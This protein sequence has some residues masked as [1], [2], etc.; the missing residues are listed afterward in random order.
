MG[1]Q[2]RR[3]PADWQ[4]PKNEKGH[5]IPLFE[6]SYS[7]D[8]A[9]WDERAAQ[10]AKGLRDDYNGGWQPKEAVYADMCYVEWAGAAPDESDYMPDWPTDQ[11][12]HLQM[13]DNTSEGTPI[14]PVM[15]TPE[16]LAQWLADNEASAFAGMTATYEQWLGTIKRGFAPSAVLV[17][18][19]L[20]SGVAALADTSS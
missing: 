13:Y 4:H 3:V 6:R 11:C 19:H 5:Y 10:W 1:R 20:E 7:K 15:E 16:Q 18:G 8:A 12:T 2:V 14:S 17:C 9:E